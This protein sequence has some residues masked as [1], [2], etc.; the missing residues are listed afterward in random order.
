MLRYL[1]I[2]STLLSVVATA[3]SPAPP[4]ILWLS[5]EDMD[6]S[7][8]CYGDPDAISPNLDRLAAEGVRF[9]RAF[10]VAPVCAPNRSC[11]ITGVYP[12]TL[13]TLHMR[14]GG[15]GIEKSAQP[16]LPPEVRCF[17][18]YL[19]RA[20]YYCTNNSK[21]DYNFAPTPA[22]SWDESSGKAHWKNRPDP[23]QP[24]FAVFNHVGT[25]ES[26]VRADGNALEQLRKTLG[27]EERHDPGKVR[28]PP[29]HPDT[30]VVRRQWANYHDLVTGMDQWVGEQ[31]KE[32]EEAGLAD[33]TIVVFWSDHGAGLPRH[34]RWLYDSGTH[35]PVIVRAPEGMRQRL[36]I[37]PGSTDARLVSALDF[38]PTT[39]ALA[40]VPIPSH[41]QGQAF[42][43][44]A[45][46]TPRTY[47]YSARDR[48]DERYDTIRS[49]RDQR[50]RY[51]RNFQPWVPY[52]QYIDYCERGDVQKELR[53]LA[54]EHALPAGCAWFSDA[55]KPIEELY[56]TEQDP[57]E[58]RNLAEDP[59]YGDEL[60]RLRKACGEWIRDTR[61]LGL[62]P[63]AELNR[64]EQR[65]GNRYAIHEG[66]HR[67]NPE[68]W[69]NLYQLAE[70]S[71]EVKG[72]AAGE[73]AAALESKHTAIRYWA[74][75]SL[76]RIASPENAVLHL[77]HATAD[78][79]P[80]VRV[81]AAEA[82]LRHGVNEP[83]QLALLE[84]LLKDEDMWV[85]LAAA[86]TLDYAG[87]KSR[88]VLDSLQSALEDRYN[89]YIVRVANHAVNQLLGTS[90]AVP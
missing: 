36:G 34:K 89:K 61:D 75:V 55:A 11:V 47:V 28:L 49:V 60:V 51:I 22:E 83:Q 39:L 29:Y 77:Q 81:A 16:A 1:F 66:L 63:E 20:G 33:N 37:V 82:L 86:T 31:L 70:N 72:E 54:A 18:E 62:L 78:A 76:G 44:A 88:P 25:H 85:R 3:D 68:F 45:E 2:L 59:E 17:P 5:V 57:H 40:G 13:G 64:L 46:V 42:L 9:T 67:E 56:D 80:E 21:E 12:S 6:A 87:E 43:G 14:S 90:N 41:M 4:N 53:R 69:Q 79:S 84:E 73:L 58:L 7:L 15:E 24:F 74:V 30:P 26:Q 10:T 65:F 8:G 19:R 23:K 35:V 48:M 32:L 38:A 27:S 50:F 52:A 71:G